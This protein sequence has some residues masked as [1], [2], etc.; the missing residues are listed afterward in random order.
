MVKKAKKNTEEDY[1]EKRRIYATDR[2]L[3]ASREL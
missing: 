2:G 3:Q 1:F